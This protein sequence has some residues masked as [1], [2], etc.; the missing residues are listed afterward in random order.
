M[1]PGC[2]TKKR[3][4]W[5]IVVWVVLC[6]AALFI[7]GPQASILFDVGYH[8]IEAQYAIPGAVI[9][10]LSFPRALYLTHVLS[11]MD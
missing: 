10:S 3:V 8:A 11:E 6:E 9:F 7:L 1:K 2:Y 5:T 4:F